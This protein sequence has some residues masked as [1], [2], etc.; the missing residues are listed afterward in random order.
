MN[1]AQYLANEDLFNI[2]IHNYHIITII[3]QINLTSTVNSQLT[4]VVPQVVNTIVNI[5][6]TRHV[7]LDCVLLKINSIS[8]YIQALKVH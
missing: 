2:V 8:P 7:Q 6:M 1:T 5:K 3:K 4:T